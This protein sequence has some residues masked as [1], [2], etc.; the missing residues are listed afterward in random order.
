MS[1]C[2]FKQS[3]I[4][5]SEYWLLLGRIMNKYN[6]I[7]ILISNEEAVSA[8]L[9]LSPR[10]KKEEKKCP[11]RILIEGH[12]G[13]GKTTLCRRMAL[14]WARPNSHG[15]HCGENCV[16]SFDLL[17]ILH[18]SHF[19]DENSIT[20]VITKHLF[21]K[22]FKLPSDILDDLLQTK[23]ILVLC[24]A[25]DEASTDNVLLDDLIRRQWLSN[26]TVLITSRFNHLRA[27][28]PHFNTKYSVRGF[29]EE[30]RKEHIQKFA[31][32]RKKSVD[33]FTSWIERRKHE[34]GEIMDNPLNLTLILLLVHE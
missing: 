6:S 5:N 1:R 2:I 4:A 34:L 22:D 24:D 13:A 12:P 17:F 26:S 15:E 31:K 10:G 18:S 11:T 27:A 20:D 7:N 16:H 33:K 21:P 30:Q 25:Y 32:Q 8:N 19:V 9:V 3:T 23:R 29:D 14:E 28:L